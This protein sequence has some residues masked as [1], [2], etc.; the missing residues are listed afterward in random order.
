MVDE[1][2]CLP[3]RGGKACAVNRVIQSPLKQEQQVLAGDSLHA[4]SAFEVVSKLPFKN[5][6]DAFDLLLLAQLLAITDQRFAASH[7]VA[8]LSG[9]LRTAFFNRASGLVAPI[10]LQK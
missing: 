9:R 1:L 8:V 7:R 10:A 6:I 3:A 2:S 4:G 5:E